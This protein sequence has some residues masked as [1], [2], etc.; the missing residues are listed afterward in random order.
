MKYFVALATLAAAVIAQV[1]EGCSPNFEGSF[2]VDNR[3]ITNAPGQFDKRQETVTINEACADPG[4]STFTLSDSVLTDQ[5]G[6]TGAIA[7]QG[8]FQFDKNVQVDSRYVDGF[9]ICG[10][11]S[12]ALAGTTIFYQCLVEPANREPF[13]NLYLTSQRPECDEINIQTIP[14]PSDGAV[15]GSSS[16]SAPAPAT[17]SIAAAPA[18]STVSAAPFPVPSNGTAPSPTASGAPGSPAPVPY[19]PGSGASAIIIAYPHVPPSTSLSGTASP[20]LPPRFADLK[21]RLIRGHESRIQDS[22]RRLLIALQQQRQEITALGSAIVPKIDFWH[23]SDAPKRTSFRDGLHKRGL[24]PLYEAWS[25]RMRSNGLPFFTP[26]RDTTAIP[27]AYLE[28]ENWTLEHPMTS[29][30]QGAPPGN[31]QELSPA[32]QPHLDLEKHNGEGWYQI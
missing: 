30:L 24:S 12:L 28:P 20:P 19:E 21:R 4:A 13:V 10:N 8:Q 25:Q 23:L 2:L 9:S 31:G 16:V 29:A 14:C 26:K 6:A 15:S 5:D 32:M 1:P 22:W 18:T 3:R 17:S 7:A 11:G 27:A